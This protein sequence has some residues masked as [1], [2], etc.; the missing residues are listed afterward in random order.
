MST[1]PRTFVSDLNWL[2][3]VEQGQLGPVWVAVNEST[4]AKTSRPTMIALPLAA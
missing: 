2:K 4:P 1:R 3:P